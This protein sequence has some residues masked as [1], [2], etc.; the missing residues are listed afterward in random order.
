MLKKYNI[1]GTFFL[2]GQNIQGRQ[3]IV[4]RIAAE[5]HDVFSH[6]QTHLNHWK[7]SPFNTI[8]DIHRGWNAIDSAIGIR[9]GKYPFRPPKGKMN[10]LSLMYLF[11]RRV[12][13]IYWT[14]DIGD[15]RMQKVKQNSQA[16]ALSAQNAGGA[17][18]LVHDYDRSDSSFATFIL[19]SIQGVLEMAKCNGMDV[20]P[21]SEFLNRTK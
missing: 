12:P 8:T 13:V 16:L 7:A 4:K 20:M 2:L 17:V 18:V 10:L 9:H 3:H 6:G 1:K 14:L 21:V 11:F 15:T 5:G 19:E